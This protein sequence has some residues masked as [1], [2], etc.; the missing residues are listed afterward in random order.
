MEN[1]F[2]SKK[3]EK[4]K[5]EEAMPEKDLESTGENSPEE[6]DMEEFENPEPKEPVEKLEKI[7]GALEK[8]YEK[9]VENENKEDQK[10]Q[11]GEELFEKARE[12]KEDVEKTIRSSLIGNISE[13]MSNTSKS[14][15]VR[16]GIAERKVPEVVRA[17]EEAYGNIEKVKKEIGI[18]VDL[19][20]GWGE[21]LRDLANN[22]KAEKVIGVDTNTI[23]S[24]KVAEELGDK[25]AWIKGDAVEAMKLLQDKS[26]DLCTAF[27]FLQVLD[28]EEKMAVLKEMGR[29][30][31][32]GIVIVDELKR[33][34]LGG[35]RDLF[36]NK[37]YNVGT[38]KYDVLKEEEWKEIF[39]E[40]GL[41]AEVFN[42]FG[43]NDFVA[44][45]KRI[46]EAEK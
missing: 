44:V 10:K 33:D 7:R 40:A 23:H 20:A 13:K 38:G 27:A 6:R 26:V 29:A 11:S 19:G 3:T 18:I 15:E 34:G 16:D 39:K 14:Q 37:L 35:F 45:L 41:V 42:K 24:R 36:M 43:K 31:K 46:E 12:K 9:D 28:R 4:T 30:A 1:Q 25:L 22:L 21:N 17:L 32:K 5:L 2:G 8:A